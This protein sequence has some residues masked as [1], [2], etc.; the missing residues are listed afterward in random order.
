MEA[1]QILDFIA[2]CMWCSMCACMNTQHKVQLDVRDKEPGVAR[3]PHPML[4]PNAQMMQYPQAPPS[5]AFMQPPP[6]PY[7]QPPPGYPYPPPPK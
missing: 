2:D 7:G 3:P 6:G 5:G 4:A 1:A